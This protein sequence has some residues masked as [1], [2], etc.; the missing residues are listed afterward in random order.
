MKKIIGTFLTLTNI[1]LLFISFLISPFRDE[2]DIVEKQINENGLLVQRMIFI[3]IIILSFS[4]YLMKGFKF[5]FLQI[6]NLLFGLYAILKLTL[7]FF[8]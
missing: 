6:L 1:T 3:I 8:I 2:L 7:S 5:K 4:F